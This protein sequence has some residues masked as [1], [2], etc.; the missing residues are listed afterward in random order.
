MVYLV[1]SDDFFFFEKKTPFLIYMS[2]SGLPM[3]QATRP[4]SKRRITGRDL[5]WA[6]RMLEECSNI[7]K[8][9]PKDGWPFS[10]GLN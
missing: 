5:K 7:T 1:V 8:V 2:F 10:N 4:P 6:C 9:F 3:R